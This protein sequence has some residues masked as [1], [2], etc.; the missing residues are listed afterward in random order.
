[1]RLHP[2]HYPVT[3]ARKEL[4]EFL[5]QLLDKHQL[6]IAERRMLVAGW[7][8]QDLQLDVKYERYADNQPET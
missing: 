3:A 7:L 8:D 5:L 1:M 6:T 4:T 2:R